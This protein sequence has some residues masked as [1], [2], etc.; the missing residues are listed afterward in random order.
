MII[1][2]F[3][4]ALKKGYV[5]IEVVDEENPEEASGDYAI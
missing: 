2:V 5:K 4:V 3:A 1:A